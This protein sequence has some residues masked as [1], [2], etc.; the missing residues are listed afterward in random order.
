M[1]D[2]RMIKYHSLPM[3]QA[4][5][6]VQKAADDMAEEYDLTSQWAGNTLH[7]R[8]SGVQG[9]MR[10]TESEIDLEVTLGFLLKAFKSKFVEHIEH[11]FERL[12]AKAHADHKPA[13]PAAG[14]PARASAH[15]SAPGRAKAPAKVARK[16]ARKS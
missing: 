7:F 3:T 10:V 4:R 1:A 11:N 12:L 2:I 5:A 15:A 8:R 14:T 16:A 6:L 9:E 13:K